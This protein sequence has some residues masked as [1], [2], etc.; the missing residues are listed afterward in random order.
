MAFPGGRTDPADASP[1]ATAERE[2]REE[3]GLELPDAAFIGALP[4]QVSPVRTPD[5]ALTVF[6]FVY[7]VARW[8]A[9]VLSDEVASV[10]PF[11]FGRIAAG[12]GRGVFPYTWRGTPLEL[13]CIRL[14]GALIWGMTLRMI[15]DILSRLAS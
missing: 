6:P 5:H 13:P 3:V 15:D 9:F 10:H 1:R 8:P 11:A 2:T 7:E 4:V 14:D 12:E